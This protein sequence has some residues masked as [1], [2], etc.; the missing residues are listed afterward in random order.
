M[1]RVQKL[2]AD[3]GLGKLEINQGYG[4]KFCVLDLFTFIK[5]CKFGWNFGNT[6]I[7]CLTFFIY[8]KVHVQP[9]YQF[10]ERNK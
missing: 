3:L 5:R 2:K 4:N 6:K 8:C 9:V 10:D 1:M 7:K